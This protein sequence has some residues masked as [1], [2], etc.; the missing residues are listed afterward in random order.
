MEENYGYTDRDEDTL[1][2]LVPTVSDTFNRI[3]WEQLFHNLPC[4]QL[5]ILVFL[6][7]GLKPLEIVEVL[8]FKNIAK[9]YNVSAKLKRLYREQKY[10]FID[11]NELI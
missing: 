1:G 7:L 10:R 6:Y 4:E 9:Y 8:E 5:E 11:Y 3:G 2:D